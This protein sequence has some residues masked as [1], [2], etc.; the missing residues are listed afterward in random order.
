MRFLIGESDADNGEENAS[1]EDLTASGTVAIARNE[2]K[3]ESR[4]DLAFQNAI[5]VF[6]HESHPLVIFLD[7]LQWAD[8]ATLKLVERMLADED[9]QHLLIVG[10]Y[11][12]RDMP[13]DHLLWGG[14]LTPSSARGWR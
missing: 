8:V 12:D 10:A 5:R 3:A 9:T 11:R 1:N 6:C 4:F 13:A 2:T 7:D 14:G